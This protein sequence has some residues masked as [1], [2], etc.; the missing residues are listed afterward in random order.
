MTFKNL[1]SNYKTMMALPFMVA[2]YFIATGV[3]PLAEGVDTTAT[4]AMLLVPILALIASDHID[5]YQL[6]KSGVLQLA[7]FDFKDDRIDKFL[8]ASAKGLEIYEKMAHKDIDAKPVRPFEMIPTPL[9]E[10]P[11]A[12]G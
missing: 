11:N 4:L 6:F 2:L 3:I 10:D 9:T 7:S 5:T 12:M 8:E 1:A